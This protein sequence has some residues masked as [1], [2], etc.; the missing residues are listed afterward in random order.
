MI[1]NSEIQGERE[2]IPFEHI[3]SAGFDEVK[4]LL[5]VRN[6][7]DHAVSLWNQLSKSHY[8]IL[9]P[10]LDDYFREYSFPATIQEYLEKILKEEKVTLEVYNYDSC[11]KQMLP[12]TER[13]LGLEPGFFS[14]SDEEVV[15]RSLHPEELDVLIRHKIKVDSGETLKN[16]LMEATGHSTSSLFVPLLSVQQEMWERN[17]R[18]IAFINA[19]LPET[20]KLQFRPLKGRLQDEGPISFNTGQ[21]NAIVNYY[22]LKHG[23]FKQSAE[24]DGVDLPDSS[25]NI[26]DVGTEDKK[27]ATINYRLWLLRK[28]IVRLL[29][30]GQ[31]HNSLI[32]IFRKAT[33]LP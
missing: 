1:Y 30:S 26:S 27:R 16:D 5:F 2:E 17:H 21:I 31:A 8:K 23:R 12:I 7:L 32:Q 14:K 24:Q 20:E 29:T 6:P 25:G 18:H 33:R 19:L 13:W 11:K 3:Y 10:K 15:N 4:I 9:Y 28:K 22:L